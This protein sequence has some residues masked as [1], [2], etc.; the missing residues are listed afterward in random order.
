MHRHQKQAERQRF[1][2]PGSQCCISTTR[3]SQ[4][5]VSIPPENVAPIDNNTSPAPSP[6]IETALQSC[7][8]T[9]DLFATVTTDQD[10]GTALQ[11]LFLAATANVYLAQ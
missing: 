9:P 4:T 11:Q 3:R 1:A 6:N 5:T 2:D 10:I 8:S 7:A